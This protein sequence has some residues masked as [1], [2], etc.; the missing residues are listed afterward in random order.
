MALIV[1]RVRGF[2]TAGCAVTCAHQA[3]P[4]LLGCLRSTLMAMGAES[5]LHL[6]T[7]HQAGSLD[8]TGGTEI[9]LT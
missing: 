1:W 3:F 9:T 5:R 6:T 7:A 8:P 4:C 2:L